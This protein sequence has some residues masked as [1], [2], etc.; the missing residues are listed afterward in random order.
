[1]IGEFYVT[2]DDREFAVLA[3]REYAVGPGCTGWRVMSIITVPERKYRREPWISQIIGQIEDQL[4]FQKEGG[5]AA[6]ERCDE[7]EG[8]R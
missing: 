8:G 5:A 4:E 3:E 6:H 1:M 2:I 7:L